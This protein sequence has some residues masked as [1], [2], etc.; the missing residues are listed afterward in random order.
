VRN[1]YYT[2][3]TYSTLLLLFTV[4]FGTSFTKLQL[5]RY[6]YLYD[7]LFILLIVLLTVFKKKLTLY[8]NVLIIFLFHITYIFISFYDNRVL[9]LVLRQSAL[10]TYFLFAS[11]LYINIINEYNIKTHIN[12]IVVIS[13]IGTAIQILYLILKSLKSGYIEMFVG[14]KYNYYS[15]AVILS[16]LTILS[17]ITVVIKSRIKLIILTLIVLLCIIATGHSSAVISALIIL[18]I[19][20]SRKTK[21]SNLITIITISIILII[22][23]FA[24][25]NYTD[26]NA[27]WRL[28][29]WKDALVT[30]FKKDF[31]I[32]GQGYGV[33]FTSKANAYHLGLNKYLNS[34]YSEMYLSSFHNSFITIWYHL[35]LIPLILIIAP[36]YKN[37]KNSIKRSNEYNIIYYSLIGATIWVS[38]NVILELPHSSLYYWYIY[39]LFIKYNKYVPNYEEL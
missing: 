15:P 29:Y 9:Y 32:F 24:D 6:I 28:E 20:Y 19:Y 39:Y 25:K 23:M 22:M 37:I 2:F 35:G 5:A 8:K 36:V 38:F 14:N 33:S 17:Y 21:N 30:I 16:L 11:F 10:I 7:T 27:M 3:I 18:G 34:N 26:I 31:I 1:K 12:V 4:V 13:A